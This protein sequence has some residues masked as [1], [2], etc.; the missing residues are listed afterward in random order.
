MRLELRRDSF[1]DSIKVGGLK[2]ENGLEV[3]LREIRLRNRSR[4]R[5]LVGDEGVSGIGV[6]SPEGM[7][8]GRGPVES[9]DHRELNSRSADSS[10]AG[11]AE[12]LCERDI[13]L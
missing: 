9:I 8:A 6:R 5:V 3:L 10:R 12:K 2:S 1:S 11:T 4:F 7:I 13:D